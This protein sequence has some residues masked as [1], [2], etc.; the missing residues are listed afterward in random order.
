MTE[1]PYD[2]YQMQRLEVL[3]AD[4]TLV[5]L[6]GDM[7]MFRVTESG[8]LHVAVASLT[9]EH[10]QRIEEMAQRSDE[11]VRGAITLPAG[12]T[13]VYASDTWQSFRH[14]MD[15]NQLLLYP[16]LIYIDGFDPDASLN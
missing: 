15:H 16:S 13:Y 8:C 11:D 10:R 4:G 3:L 5:N 9:L 6:S 12:V 7:V 14:A 1:S 2:N